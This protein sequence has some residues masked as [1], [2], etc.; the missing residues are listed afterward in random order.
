MNKYLLLLLTALILLHSCGTKTITR[1]YYTL[2]YPTVADTNFTKSVLTDAV[3][4]IL[5]VE[6]ASVYSQSRIA[7]RLRTHE[8]SYYIYHQWAGIPSDEIT[9]LLVKNLKNNNLFT[10][11]S[12]TVWLDIPYFYIKSRTNHLEAI[13]EDDELYAH[14]SM[15]MEFYDKLVDKIAAV[16]NFN[17]TEILEE[18]DIN[19]LAAKFSEIMWD[20]FQTLAKK[21]KIYLIENTAQPTKK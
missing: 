21:I 17:R 2:D 16:H 18:R 5:P 20:E 8:I 7:V 3:C 6:I 4:E 13:D 11:V 9:E 12:S 1:K 14:I 10:E 19:L 15:E